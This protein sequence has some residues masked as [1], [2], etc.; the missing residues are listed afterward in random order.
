MGCLVLRGGRLLLGRRIDDTYGNG[1]Y[2]CG[3]GHLEPGENLAEAARREIR[4][5]W[6]IE[7]DTPRF[8]CVVNLRNYNGT[9]WVS[10]GFSGD[11]VS[12]K[13]TPEIA[14]E[15]AGH[16]WYDLDDLPSPLFKP[17]PPYVEALRTGKAYF[18]L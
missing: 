11:W 7:I 4:E 13:P 16:G 12:G 5:E 15:F 9:H 1:E 8:L 18:E 2:S 10:F 14:K 17:V 3:G 6:G